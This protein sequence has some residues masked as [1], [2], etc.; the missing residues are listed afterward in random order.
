MCL[1]QPI[2]ISLSLTSSS[3]F[4]LATPV[5]KSPP[6]PRLHTNT[7]GLSR[8]PFQMSPVTSPQL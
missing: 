8:I 3:T 7:F 2:E 1:T 5:L 4:L 6:L